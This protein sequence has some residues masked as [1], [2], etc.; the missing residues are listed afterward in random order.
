[1]TGQLI[2][3]VI[4]EAVVIAAAINAWLFRYRPN[5]NDEFAE[6][7]IGTDS[8]KVRF[9]VTMTKLHNGRQ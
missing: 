1:M 9:V 3:L 6:D 7:A 8:L 4:T 2:G 5:G